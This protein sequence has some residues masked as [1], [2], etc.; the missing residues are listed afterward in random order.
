ML[1]DYISEPNNPEYNFSLALHYDNIGQT[2]SALSFYLR[3]AE[4]TDDNLLKYECLIRGSMC[5]NKQGT[6]KFTVKGMLQHAIAIMPK[7][8]E[9]YYMLS[10]HY[11]KQENN[12]GKWFDSYMMASIGLEVS[13]FS[14][15]KMFRTETEYREKY[16]M[17][18]QKANT[19]WWCGLC[20]ESKNMFLDL[21]NNYDMDEYHIN[22]VHNNLV[23][24]NAFTTEKIFEYNKSKM[25]DLKVKFKGVESIEKNFSES[26]QDMFV[27]T[28]LDGKRNGTYLEIGAGNTFYG[29]NTALLEQSFDW[30]GVSL[31]VVPEFVE[32]FGKERKNPCLLKD[33]T[34]VDYDKF[35]TGL[36]FDNVIDYLQIDCD[37][38]EISLKVL[39]S[40]PLEKFKFRVITFEHD[41]YADK[42]KNVKDMSR[43]FL[44]SY[45]YEL[46]ASDISPDDSNRPYEDWWVHPDLVDS[47]MLSNMKATYINMSDLIK[48][49]K[50]NR[51]LFSSAKKA[52]DFMM[53]K[54]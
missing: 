48:G 16:Q 38:A 46:I 9:A 8:P 39:Y 30:T 6:R 26:Y 50:Q 14:D 10:V 1:L 51:P 24:L 42:S 4:R 7:R 40:M 29:N 36:G 18:F 21:Q 37:P 5:F 34:T 52:E 54:C 27:L 31:D 22:E 33:A 49:K 12:E 17:I 23:K 45:G 35:L 28:M 47:E 41:Y 43:K 25:K 3:T 19:A 11:E 44:N 13:D 2:A 20:E 15:T 32:A 53:G